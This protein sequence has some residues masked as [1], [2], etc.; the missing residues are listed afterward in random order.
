MSEYAVVIVG[1]GPAGLSAAAELGRLG[2]TDVL[3]VEREAEPGGIPR[4]SAHQG[5]GLLDL[6]RTY[7]GPRYAEILTQRAVA[8]GAQVLVATTVSEVSP[9]PEARLVLTSAA[10]RREVTARMV[11]FATGARERPRAARLLPGDRGAGVFT[12]G[13]LQQWVRAEMPVGTRAVILG[14]EHVSYS[15]VLTLR[16]AGV[17]IGAL[18]TELP[19]HQSVR[20]TSRVAKLLFGAPTLT[21]HRVVELRGQPRLA[22]VVIEE[23]ATARQTEITADVFVTTGDWIPDHDLARRSGLELDPASNGP[24]SDVVGRTTLEGL[25]VVGN[26]VHPVE[27]ADRCARNGRRVARSIAAA[28]QT[29][30]PTVFTA[31]KVA[32]P[33]LWAWPTLID[34]YA[35]PSTLVLR[36]IK[37]ARGATV[38]ARQGTRV[39]GSARLRGG[40]PNQHTTVSG[41]ILHGA[42]GEE[43]ITLSL[44]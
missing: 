35:P 31:I 23:I 30:T 11:L 40:V 5:F 16:H 8:A 26:L 10:G 22:S 19:H 17:R 41:S 33:L 1:A 24:L 43:P 20:G 25:R 37:F 28:L 44:N 27:T 2:I 7:A 42:L 9:G 15:A 39:L 18:V 29:E 6:H 4:H 14:A 13:Q 32:S 34:P 36:T 12:T 21:G 3:V 38:S